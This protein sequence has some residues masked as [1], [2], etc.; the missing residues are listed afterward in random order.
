M[1]DPH[2]AST[3]ESMASVLKAYQDTLP[4]FMQTANQNVLPT[5]QAKLNAAQQTSPGWA[6]LQADIFK[7]VG[8]LLAQTGSD[9]SSQNALNQAK[10]DSAVLAGPG[11]D[12]V[13]QAL[14]LQKLSD[15]EYYKGRTDVSNNLS[16]LFDSID[17]S[18]NLSGGETEALRRGL[19]SE[20]NAR[21]TT[22][23]PSMS[24][25]LAGAQKYGFAAK[26]RQDQAKTQLG[27][28]LSVA[29]G[30]LPAMKSGTDVFQVATGR[31]SSNNTG[32]NK[33][34]GVN[35]NV[36]SEAFGS[37]NN[38]FNSANQMKLNENQIESERRDGLDRF[39]ETFSST[40][41]SL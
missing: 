24:E 37:A 13:T 16:R 20:S 34:L 18:G 3:P 9:I 30:A 31:P 14:E 33:F 12:V 26:E 25:T 8:P 15:P 29:T 23:S 32:D 36:G 4:A 17:L 39:N 7:N 40:I 5:E 6:Q 41:G 28:A 10:S 27:Q 35:Q 19:A 22:T 1:A 21:G 38:I 2:P 11:K